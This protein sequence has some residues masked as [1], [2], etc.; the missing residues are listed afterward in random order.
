MNKD[1]LDKCNFDESLENET[2]QDTQYKIDDDS[3][4]SKNGL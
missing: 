2:L 1:A 3:G 4:T